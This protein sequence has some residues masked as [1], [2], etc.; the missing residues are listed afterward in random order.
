M[1]SRLY[2]NPTPGP[3]D[4]SVVIVSHNTRDLLRRALQSLPKDCEVIVVDNASSDG[5][6]GM[7][8]S[9]FPAVRLVVNDANVGFGAANNQG[10]RLASRP[11]VLLLNSDAE[12][13]P[14]AVEALAS[15]F[16][17]PGVVGAGGRLEFPDGR[18]QESAAGA[19]TLWAVFCE[20]T[21][22]EKAF[23]RAPVLCPYWRSARLVRLGVGPWEVEQVMGACLML[24][25]IE[26]FDERFFLYCEDTELCHR[27]R[28]HGR[29]LYVPQALSLIH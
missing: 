12:A 4:V 27:L 6:A 24:R 1:R 9:E 26:F 11:L 28:R 22:L 8:R 23:P 20:Q 5:S 15:V 10:L 25:P 29:I 14:G 16:A 2:M 3:S 7:V 19:L 18:L 17:D 21:L 13:L